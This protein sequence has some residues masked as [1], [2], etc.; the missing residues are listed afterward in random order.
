MP[1][2]FGAFRKLALSLPDAFEQGHMGHP[3]FRVRGKI[4]ATLGY[5]DAEHGMVKLTSEQQRAFMDSAPDVFAPIK[6]KWGQ[7]GATAVRLRAATAK[8]LRPA[9]MTAWRNVAEARVA[10]PTAR[11]RKPAVRT[12]SSR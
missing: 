8:T 3:D 9:L 12:R 2:T 6:G 5:P 1:M 11:T 7:R 10:R 4:F